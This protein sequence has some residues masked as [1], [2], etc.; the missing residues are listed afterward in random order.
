MDAIHRATLALQRCR[1][2]HAPDD[3][4]T[5]FD[6]SVA[7]SAGRTDDHLV[8]RGTV[9]TPDLERRARQAV[10]EATGVTATSEL[11]VLEDEREERAVS[12]AVVPVRDAAAADAEQ[13]TQALYGARVAAFDSEGGWTRIRSPDG[14]LGWVEREFLAPVEVSG[15]DAVVVED[16][17]SDDSDGEPAH[18]IHVGTDCRIEEE[19]VGRD[20]E[21]ET[22]VAFR[23]G[24]RDALPASAVRRPRDRS[25]DR[26]TGEGVVAAAHRYLGTEYEWG[27]MTTDGIDCSGLA[28]VAYR[29][30]GVTLPRDADQQRAMGET[31]ERADLRA[32]DLLFF[33][34]HVAVSLGGDEYV[35][36]Y[37][38]EDSVV[39]SSLDSERDDYAADLDEKFELARRV[40]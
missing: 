29:T 36:A 33:P 8:L 22:V 1:T 14:Y 11:T 28:W 12:A 2:R 34:G 31:V 38:G 21:T 20:G 30:Q 27:G 7:E 4:V 25:T 16:V 39:V 24:E 13:V 23:T 32:G 9:S 17:H 37:G 6:V 3:R 10:E 26:P 15:A 18:P 19:S 5:V 40:L 35:H